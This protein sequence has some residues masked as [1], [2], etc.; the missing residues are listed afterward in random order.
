MDQAFCQEFGIF[1][2]GVLG[3]VLFYFALQILVFNTLRIK[4]MVITCALLA[5]VSSFVVWIFFYYVTGEIYLDPSMRAVL[6]IAGF[7]GSLGFSG[8]YIIL[9]PLS[10]DR[11]LSAHMCIHLYRAKG[12][13]S[14]RELMSKYTQDVIFQ[15]R[16]RE[17][18]IKGVMKRSKGE[19]ILT[20]R[21]RRV[22]LLF[23]GILKALRLKE[24]F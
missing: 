11:S 10:A 1:V 4:E 14:E 20:N 9:G 21:G 5:F 3:Y 18:A 7:Y 22:A 23:L 8:A 12:R 2:V 6:S 13:M 16:F 24:N 17:Y 15:K 19:L